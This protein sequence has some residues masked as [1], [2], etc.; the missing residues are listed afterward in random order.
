MENRRR[1]EPSGPLDEL[2]EGWVFH[3]AFERRLA[4]PTVAAYRSD[5]NTH[6]DFLRER[7]IRRP[8]EVSTDLL[9]EAL[10][11]MH[12]LGLAPRSRLRARA[13]I[14]GFYRWVARQ[15]KLEASPA[16]AL[17]APRKPR[18]LP[19]VLT[20]D[21]TERLIAACGGG[22][23]L[24][25]RDRAL[26]EIG[27]GAGLRVSELTG[28]GAEDVDFREHWLLVRGKGNKERMVPLGNRA[29]EALRAWYTLARPGLIGRRADPGT[30]FVNARGGRLSRMGFWKILRGRAR[31]AG[32]DETRIH[33]HIL[34]HSYATHLLQGGASLRIIQELLGH[35]SL[36]TTQIYTAV[37]RG[38]L[39][40]IHREFHPRG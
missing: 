3:L 19:D 32:L 33:P 22:A 40:R 12:D 23:P 27:Y 25:R 15:R 20:V 29:L 7:G 24:D 26:I 9:R 35:A 36:D 6:L 37:D 13:S 16:D 1:P 18:A 17:E 14:R 31:A 21:E 11:A 39:S 38:Y 10:A 34:R 4:T 8:E 28:I 2:L 30:V 5:L